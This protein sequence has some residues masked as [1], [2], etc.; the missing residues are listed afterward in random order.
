MAC[1][2]PSTNF[3]DL[4]EE[5]GPTEKKDQRPMWPGGK[6]GTFECVAEVHGSKAV[7]KEA[8]EIWILTV[9]NL[10][11]QFRLK[12]SFQNQQC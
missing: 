7:S 6:S 9:R 2:H 12:I 5:K 1:D 11:G 10:G 8:A 3:S 4:P